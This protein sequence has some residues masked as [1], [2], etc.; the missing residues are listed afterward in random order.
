MIIMPISYYISFIQLS[1]FDKKFDLL[2]C[3]FV[4]HATDYYGK[5]L[6]LLTLCFHN[7][8]FVMNHSI[9]TALNSCRS[10]VKPN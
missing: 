4:A 2:V 3:F 7:I 8:R 9:R 5:L 1:T 6:F 10:L